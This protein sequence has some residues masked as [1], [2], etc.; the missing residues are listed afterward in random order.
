MS[1]GKDV[2]AI[3]GFM[4]F[5]LLLQVIFPLFL[6]GMLIWA[7]AQP[8]MKLSDAG[9]VILVAL[10]LWAVW[11]F[12][13]LFKWFGFTIE[14]TDE[15]LTARGRTWKWDEI[16]GARAKNAFKFDT[17]IEL[18]AKDG[19]TLAIPA[20]IQQNALVLTLVEKHVPGLIREQ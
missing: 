6:I 18:T 20:A 5:Y 12:V 17:F 2:F 8:F 9:P 16:A 19:A 4:R 3:N 15:G 1:G 13:K 11:E 10:G 14:I 7:I